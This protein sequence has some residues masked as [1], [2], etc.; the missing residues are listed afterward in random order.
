MS[1]Q[2]KLIKELNGTLDRELKKSESFLEKIGR[3][4]A[5]QR[6]SYF[7]K[8]NAQIAA[9]TGAGGILVS[10]GTIIAQMEGIIAQSPANSFFALGCMALSGAVVVA[11]AAHHVLTAKMLDPI[12]SDINFQDFKPEK[13]GKIF[14]K[15]VSNRI[16]ENKNLTPE[17]KY[18]VFDA[19]KTT[20]LEKV[21]CHYNQ[22]HHMKDFA[23]TIKGM[24][25][26]NII[27]DSRMDL[28][29][30]AS[31]E[32]LENIVE[33]AKKMVAEQ[34]T[35]TKVARGFDLSM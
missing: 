23:S 7:D 17:Q 18:E 8:A 10:A 28:F 24:D 13:V 4:C 5:K 6:G 11:S 33:S 34:N 29:K 20:F 14:S 2:E 19:F 21:S 26:N 22:Q 15:I 27:H 9:L 12:I 30:K 3:Y 25:L 1:N 32:Q 35:P 31:S 16:I